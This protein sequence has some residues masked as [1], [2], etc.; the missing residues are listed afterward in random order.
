MIKRKRIYLRC[1]FSDISD[2]ASFVDMD[3]NLYFYSTKYSSFN[4]KNDAYYEVSGKLKHI[5]PET[6]H[7][8]DIRVY[9]TETSLIERLFKIRTILDD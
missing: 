8:T 5:S 2:M 9:S 6:I 7:I 1:I 3:S 4:F